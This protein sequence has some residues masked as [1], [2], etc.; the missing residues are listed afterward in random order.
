MWLGKR[1]IDIVRYT[2]KVFTPTMAALFADVNAPSDEF[3]TPKV[4]T[5]H[6]LLVFFA[7]WRVPETRHSS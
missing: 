1:D 4:C 2:D 3:G 7:Y 6:I 5:T